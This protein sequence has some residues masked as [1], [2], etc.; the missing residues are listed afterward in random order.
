MKKTQVAVQLFSFSWTSERRS[1]C[2]WL[3]PAWVRGWARVDVGFTAG[4]EVHCVS[5]SR[6]VR[7][8]STEDCNG[9]DSAESINVLS[10]SVRAR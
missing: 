3:V 5:L 1:K 10:C 9:A 2:M 8:L 6:S 7:S 4:K